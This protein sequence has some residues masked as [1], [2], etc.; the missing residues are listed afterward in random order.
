MTLATGSRGA[1]ARKLASDPAS[2]CPGQGFPCATVAL[3]SSLLGTY[4]TQVSAYRS[5]FP[6]L[7]AIS[8]VF[9]GGTDTFGRG[10]MQ[11]FSD[12][13][14]RYGIYILGSNDQAPFRESVDPSEIDRLP[15]PRPPAAEVGVRGHRPQG[16][17]R[18]VPVGAL[19]GARRGPAAAAQ[20]GAAEQEGAAHGHRAHA[21]DRERALHG[22]GRGGEPAA[23][24]P[25][26]HRS[27]PRLRHEPARLRLR[28]PAR[29]RGPVLGH[30]QVLHA[31]PGPAGRQRGHA[32]RGQPRPVGLG[33]ALL[34]AARLDA[35]DLARGL[36]S[37]G[38]ASPT[39]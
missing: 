24:P 35:L 33:R 4:S 16:V 30:E 19:P 9:T 36:R 22:S 1:E 18:G 29:G 23:V 5:R 37:D 8:A 25:P 21:A 13:A 20:R 28:R 12:M 39:T 11:V 15:R 38:A 31:L 26:R 34:A 3:I 2:I 32:G 10:W 6:T 17:Q 27:A 14:R 7:P